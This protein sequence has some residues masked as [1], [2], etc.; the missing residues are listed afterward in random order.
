MDSMVEPTAGPTAEHV[1]VVFH[2]T[3]SHRA[4][5]V[6]WSPD[7]SWVAVGAGNLDADPNGLTVL[8]AESGNVRWRV[9]EHWCRAIAVSPDAQRVAISALTAGLW[10]I[11][12]LDAPTGREIWQTHG[13]GNLEF[14]PDSTLLG[15]VGY[16]S[17]GMPR[18]GVFVLDAATG[19]LLHQQGRCLAKPVFSTDSRLMST[20]SPALV[21]SRDG[22]VVWQAG[23]HDG[24]ASASAFTTAGDGVIVASGRYGAIIG[25]D[26][27]PAAGTKVERSRV[28]AADLSTASTGFP[29]SIRVGPGCRS[30][31]FIGSGFVGLSSAADGRTVFRHRVPRPDT[32]NAVSFR[33][34]ASQVAVNYFSPAAPM[35]MAKPGLDVLDT[36]TGTPAWS[37]TGVHPDDVAFS[38]D[39]TRVAA[40]G[41]NFVRVYEAGRPARARRACGG[42]VTMVAVSAA[43]AG[44]AA[45]VAAGEEPTLTVFHAA[46]GAVLFERVQ[47]GTVSS[48][49]VSPD[50]HSAATGSADGH[51]LVFDT[52]TQQRWGA[53]Q[54]GPVNAVVFSPDSRWLATAGNDRSARLFDR[55]LPPD[56]DPDDHRPQWTRP[57]PH[58]VTHLAFGPDGTWVATAALDRKVRILSA[59]TGDELHA[60]EHD[61]RIR[62]LSVGARGLVATASDDGSASVIDAATGQRRLRIEHPRPLRVVTLSGDGSLLATA[63]S[64]ADVHIW[65][66]DGG[67]AVLVRRLTARA[68]VLTLAFHPAGRRLTV[69]TEHPM[70]D[71]IDAESG[72][73]VDRLIHPRPVTQLGSGVDG[74]LLATGCEDDRVRVYALESR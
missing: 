74:V 56:A 14:S 47:S 30:V 26:V 29:D 33:P 68:A 1:R 8:D 24:F 43:T 64:D 4:G 21:R 44:V 27:E 11:R 34:D 37:D 35:E 72:A 65:R 16:E 10:H 66:I 50:G 17:E 32:D 3:V 59:E 38:H 57:H 54:S 36:A 13:H 70:V 71:I 53:R 6:V 25:Y 22:V 45:V 28:A 69:A 7:G 62:A 42:R 49:A 61:A 31:A 63:G 2:A 39:G 51:C 20:G 58:S 52:D 5:L 40:A 15:V 73:A 60:F 41:V 12:M 48:L 19:A 46:G 18:P 67:D 23:E 9:D 55:R